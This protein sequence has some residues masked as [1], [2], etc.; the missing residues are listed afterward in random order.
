MI[1]KQLDY[2]TIDDAF[3]GSQAWFRNIVM[4]IGGCAAATAC[5]S[6]IYFGR[7]FDRPNLYPF[8]LW[9]LTKEDYIRFS[10]KMKPYIRPRVRG[11][12]KLEW[13]IEGMNQYL[14]DVNEKIEMGGFSGNHT[15]EEAESLIR[16]QIDRGYPIPY[17]LLYHQDKETFKDFIWHWFL[18][19]GYREQDGRFFITVATYGQAIEFPLKELWDTGHEEK[20]GLIYY[21][22]L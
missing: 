21:K 1:E 7:T 14:G 12:H 11:V 17:L 19:V 5:D 20:G 6:C 9:N 18:T 15:Y 16:Q 13:Y 22:N 2:F 4:N 8:D 10:Q 3:G